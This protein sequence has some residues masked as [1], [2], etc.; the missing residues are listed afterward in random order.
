MNTLSHL[1]W[2]AV[3]ACTIVYFALGAL[4]FSPV[5]F[6]KAWMDGHGIT[7][8]TDEETRAKM[9]K[10]MPKYMSFT[11]SVCLIAVIALACLISV[12][13]TDNWMMGAKLGIIAAYF[14]ATTIGLSHMHTK[15][16][17]KTFSIDAGYHAVGLIITGI[18][19]SIW[20]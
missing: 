7:M 9:R 10:E 19:L 8:P 2:L 20:H 15:K 12:T 5:L 3:I 13:H 14:G 16:S 6:V 18:I 1:N 17:F 11:F 4:W